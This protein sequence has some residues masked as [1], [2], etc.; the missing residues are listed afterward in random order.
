MIELRHLRYFVAVGEEL[1]F[2]RAAARLRLAQPALWR[3]VGALERELG[4]ALLDRRPREIRLTEAGRSFLEDA[5][6]TLALVD[7]SV[8][9]AKRVAE[10][11]IGVLRIAFN[12]IAA[13]HRVLPRLFQSFRA[14]HPDIELQLTVMLSQRQLEALERAEID[15]GFLFH[16]PAGDPT[17]D[18]LKVAEDSFALAMPVSHPLAAAPDL[19]LADLDGETFIMPSRTLNR[20]LYGKLMA[21]CL[22]GGLV[23]RIV[24]EVNNEHTVLNLVAIGMGLSF[25]NASCGPQRPD[26]VVLRRVADLDIPLELELVWAKASRSP[27]LDRFVALTDAALAR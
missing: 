17:L 18:G 2:H 23:P 8:E 14:A 10:G 9:R 25:L 11:Q 12:E 6:R 16:R 13:R 7:A 19:K 24:Q 3:Q 21:A 15:A 20:A 22:A 5:R 27:V 26:D 1:N 4:V